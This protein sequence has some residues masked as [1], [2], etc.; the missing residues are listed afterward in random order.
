M[1]LECLFE[2]YLYKMNNLTKLILDFEEKN[3]DGENIDVLENMT[4]YF[5]SLNSVELNLKNNYIDNLGFQ[6]ML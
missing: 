6:V 4:P 5:D 1:N 2:N 3:I